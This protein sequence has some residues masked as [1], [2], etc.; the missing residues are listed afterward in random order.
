MLSANWERASTLQKTPHFMGFRCQPTKTM[1]FNV[2]T[3]ILACTGG[4]GTQSFKRKPPMNNTKSSP[5]SIVFLFALLASLPFVGCEKTTAQTQPS[6]SSGLDKSEVEE[7]QAQKGIKADSA[8]S[9]VTP[10]K[11]TTQN[12]SADQSPQ[13]NPPAQSLIFEKKTIR[14]PG[15]RNMESHTLLVPKGWKLKG[16]AEWANGNYFR[17]LPSPEIKVT[18]PEGV[19]VNVHST[20]L[21]SDPR[22]NAEM[23]SLGIKRPVEG[24]SDAGYPVLECP[25][26][27]RDWK[28][29]F[30]KKV[31]PQRRPGATNIRVKLPIVD[32]EFTKAL[33]TSAAALE[34]SVEQSN[35]DARM[36]GMPDSS[37][38]D[39]KGLVI[40]CTYE[41]NGIVWE[42]VSVV[43]TLKTTSLIPGMT[44]INWTVEPNLSF[45]APKGE[46][47]ANMPKLIALIS[48][49]RPTRE[50]MDMLYKHVS[51]MQQIDRKAFVARSETTSR[52]LS[53]ISDIQM[54]GWK[55]RQAIRDE[56]DKKFSN[57]I[58]GVNDYS[59]NGY[60]YQLPA[61]YDHAYIGNDDTVILTND[62]LFN[63]S[64]D[65]QGTTNWSTMDQVR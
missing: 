54:K 1:Y 63:P 26:R 58:R 55:D 37:E 49:I 31:I 51:R 41:E 15:V 36:Y 13:K 28:N 61:G 9:K 40:E 53:E 10:K 35:R 7:T 29:L 8:I 56:G 4:N 30:A 33:R 34:Q 43:G 21:Y 48:S 59:H 2:T 46:L 64:V 22:P 25:D 57:Y 20:S 52:T 19:E 24:A 62:S 44:Q 27:L 50:W 39:A 60:D 11:K 14:D 12:R 65:L 16:Q 6:D 47:E 38:F 42:E 17:L 45:R 3:S 18:S 32:P 23:R 5:S